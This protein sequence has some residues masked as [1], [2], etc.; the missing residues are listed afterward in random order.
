MDDHTFDKQT[1]QDW[2]KTIEKADKS[3]RDEDIY[4]K[5]N[6]WLFKISPKTVLDVGCGQGI[7]SEKLSL[8]DIRYTGIDP[9]SFLIERAISLYGNENRK[10]SIGNIYNIPFSDE[11]YEATFSVLVWHLLADLN[12]ASN[13][14]SR[15]LEKNGRF[16]II[17]ANPNA[18]PEWIQF[19]SDA[20]IKGKKLE[21][22][23]VLGSGIYSR[24]TLYLHNLEEITEAL[25]QSNLF[26]QGTAQFR[27]SKSSPESKMLIALWG[28]KQE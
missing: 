1:A 23:M 12:K 26:I 2:I 27:T 28:Q 8:E 3:L 21:G 17:T 5:L 6:E 22:T 10:F 7:C 24:D 19:Y 4:P 20:Q 14:L 13:Q 9:S 16:F 11:S 15:V 25:R 18:Y